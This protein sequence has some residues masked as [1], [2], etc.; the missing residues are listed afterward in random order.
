MEISTP[1]DW[2]IGDLKIKGRGNGLTTIMKQIL[3]A[4]V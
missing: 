1:E 3:M 4:E 2:L